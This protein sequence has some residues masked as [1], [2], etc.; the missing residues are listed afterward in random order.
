MTDSEARRI[1]LLQEARQFS[2]NGRD[3]PPIHPRYHG[4]N[5]NLSEIEDVSK[6]NSTLGIRTIIA[7]ALLMAF[8]SADTEQ[9]TYKGWN[10]EKISSHITQTIDIKTIWKSL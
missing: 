4:I 8:I 2:G 10:T 3:L 7:C 5:R 1:Q 9:I 6:K